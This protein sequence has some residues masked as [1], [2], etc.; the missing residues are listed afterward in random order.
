MKLYKIYLDKPI[1]KET[2][3]IEAIDKLEGNGWYK[4]GTVKEMLENG[5]VL[6]DPF[7]VYTKSKE[8]LKDYTK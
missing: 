3:L 4:E 8:Q 1:I 7:C 5:S 2:T 6:H